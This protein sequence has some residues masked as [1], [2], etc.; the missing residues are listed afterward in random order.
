M[1]NKEICC[2]TTTGASCIQMNATCVG[3]A[4]HCDGAEDCDGGRI[5]CLQTG[6]DGYRSTCL[7]AAD[8]A[9]ADGATLCR[10]GVD[11]P[12]QTP[13]C[14]ASAIAMLSVCR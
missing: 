6:S 3:S 1:D 10:T 4:F 5:C 7:R 2:A 14:G 11:C 9:T 13:T 12:S 8:C